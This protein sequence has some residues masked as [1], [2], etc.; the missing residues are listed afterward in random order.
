MAG[1]AIPTNAKTGTAETSAV[2]PNAWFA[3][4]SLEN[5]PNK[6]DI[7]VV[8]LISNKGEGAIWAAPIFRRIM[9]IYFFGHPQTVY[10]G[11]ETTFGVLNQDYGQPA[12]TPTPTAAP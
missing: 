8:V 9:E 5:T 12:A 7:A 10:P 6:P 11:I 1:L 4:Y 3:G 2:E